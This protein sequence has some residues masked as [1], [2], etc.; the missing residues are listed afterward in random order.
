MYYAAWL[1]SAD[2]GAVVE[3]FPYVLIWY[4]AELE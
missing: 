4:G 2:A 1:V 3:V